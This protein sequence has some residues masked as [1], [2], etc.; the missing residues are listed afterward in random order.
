M[1]GNFLLRVQDGEILGRCDEKIKM[2]VWLL[3][4][5]EFLGLNSSGK[6]IK[7]DLMNV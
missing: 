7:A 2:Y 6:A 4:Q 5:I 1:K 3:I